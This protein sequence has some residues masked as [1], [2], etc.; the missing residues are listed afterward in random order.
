MRAVNVL[1]LSEWE[2]ASHCPEFDAVSL[3]TLQRGPGVFVLA[4]RKPKNALRSDE[5]SVTTAWHNVTPQE[6]LNPQTKPFRTQNSRIKCVL[7]T[8]CWSVG[9][10]RPW[11]RHLAA[12]EACLLR[13][14]HKTQD[15]HHNTGSITSWHQRSLVLWIL[16]WPIESQSDK[17]AGWYFTRL[18]F[19]CIRIIVYET[20]RIIH[21]KRQHISCVACI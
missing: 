18:F 6:C 8:S 10:G 20:L 14:T 3:L 13:W 12:K 16:K 1:W 17:I 9:C 11:V 15:S 21:R 7:S 2:A 4:K 5:T 19:C